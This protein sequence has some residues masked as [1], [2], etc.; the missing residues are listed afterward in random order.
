[1]SFRALK[2]SLP[3]LLRMVARKVGV[4]FRIAGS[5]A[6]TDGKIV[7]VPYGDFNDPK[8]CQ[9][10]LGMT[11]H[12][13]GHILFT[14]FEVGAK[15]PTD[16]EQTADPS[17][18]GRYQLLRW[19]NNA[20]E[21]VRM[22][23]RVIDKYPGARDILADCVS[24]IKDDPEW[25]QEVTDEDTPLSALQGYVLYRLRAEVLEQPLLNHAVQAERVL[26]AK[27]GDDLVQRITEKMFEV[28]QAA[29]SVDSLRIANDLVAMVEHEI[30]Q[31]QN[32]PPQPSQDAQGE[33][34]GS[35]GSQDQQ[36]QGQGSGQSGD[37][38]DSQSGAQAQDQNPG[39]S[40][41][42]GQGQSNGQDQSGGNAGAGQG[43]GDR[44]QSLQQLL[45]GE[46]TGRIADLSEVFQKT[47]EQAAEAYQ[48]ES[49]DRGGSMCVSNEVEDADSN[50]DPSQL[51]A[52]IQLSTTRLAGQLQGL[53]EAYAEDQ[54]ENATRGRT[55]DVRSFH[56]VYR[57][58]F[59]VFLEEHE[60]P[61]VDTAVVVLLDR[62]GSMCGSIGLA[63]QC[64]ASAA[65]AI[66]K[67]PDA[68]VMVAAFPGED[69]NIVRL[70]KAGE[71][72]RR[73]LGR[74]SLH[75]TGGT[76]TAEALWWAGSEIVSLDATRNI[77]ILCTD[78]QPNNPA[79]AQRIIRTLRS[80][81]VEVIGVGIES[82]GKQAVR[83]LLGGIDACGVEKIDQLAPELF[84]VLRRKLALDAAA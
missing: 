5:R 11:V 47:V 12:E 50:G 42:N 14:D 7:Y 59:D 15:A 41:G 46:E 10:V 31:E 24:S 29:T 19:L 37:G 35:Q 20:V 13:G 68:R 55:F 40:S 18:L 32:P 22:E 2:H 66:E 64:V 72:V 1:M 4:T 84:G 28:A 36:Q 45:S 21:D 73:T 3:I 49:G 74:Y 65:L 27:L 38:Q 30:Q 60:S 56:K 81:G 79:G 70:T 43:L 77:V 58:E 67:V 34:E 33:G 6:M 44:L 69:A 17:A 26:K 8:Y 61:H 53:L 80:A 71:S 23:C 57:G 82:S 52:K 51:L 76:P 48:A 16:A 83:A 54:L 63:Q 9:Q 39:G 78:G 62:S 75:A 25:F